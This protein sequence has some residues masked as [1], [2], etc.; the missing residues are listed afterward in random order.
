MNRALLEK[1]VAELP[2]PLHGDY[3]F[4]SGHCIQRLLKNSAVILTPSRAH[5]RR[6]QKFREAKFLF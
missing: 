3:V 6:T 2:A 5:F 1:I 4:G